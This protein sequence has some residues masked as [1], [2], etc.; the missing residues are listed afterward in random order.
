MVQGR[1]P[2]PTV[3]GNVHHM[4]NL[5]GQVVEGQRR[6]KTDHRW[7]QPQGDDQQVRAEAGAGEGDRGVTDTGMRGHG[8]TGTRGH[9]DT[10][11]GDAG[12]RGRA[13]IRGFSRPFPA[14]QEL[15]EASMT[16][17]SAKAVIGQIRAI[18]SICVPFHCG[19]GV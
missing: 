16:R 14:P 13:W 4:G 8:D 15:A 3:Q 9:G 17:V 18:R 12:T 1:A 11:N 2:G 6:N 7:R 19:Q 10:G 5:G